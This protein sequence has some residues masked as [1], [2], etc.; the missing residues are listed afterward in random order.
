MLTTTD[1]KEALICFTS[2]VSREM[3]I[4]TTKIEQYTPTRMAF[5]IPTLQ[6]LNKNAVQWEHSY[7]I[8]AGNVK[9]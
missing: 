8:A 3:Q 6:S 1:S 5:K 2:L 9:W 4:K 7:Y